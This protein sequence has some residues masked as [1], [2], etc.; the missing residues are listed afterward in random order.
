[1]TSNSRSF[2]YFRLGMVSLAQIM[3]DKK[4]LKGDEF[5]RGF[6]DFPIHSKFTQIFWEKSEFLKKLEGKKLNILIVE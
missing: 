4:R 5:C 1:M 2:D 3:R 6:E